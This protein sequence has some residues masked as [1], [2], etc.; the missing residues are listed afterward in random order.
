MLDSHQLLYTAECTER[1]APKP[2]HE[3]SKVRQLYLALYE[4]ITR[5]DLSTGQLLPSSRE[6]SRQLSL[7]RNTVI[8]V[9]TQLNDEGLTGSAGRGGTR[10]TYDRY[11]VQAGTAQRSRQH[12]S[13][14]GALSARS[15]K[16]LPVERTG[17]LLARG[18]P[19]T[20]LFPREDWRRALV[21]ASR[22][23]RNQLAYQ[24]APLASLQQ[25][26]ARYLAIYRSL[27]VD[28]QQIII[29]SSTRQ[30]LS[31]AATLYADKGDCAWIESPGYQGA[32]EAFSL[33]GL[34]LRAMPVDQQGSVPLPA[35][36]GTAPRIIYLTPCF[37]YPGGSPLSATRRVQF[38]D[39]AQQHRAVIFEDDYDSEFR[40]DSEAR[41]ALASEVAERGSPIVLH[42]GTFSKL[43]FP[44]ARIAWLV[45][46]AAHVNAACSCLR[47]LGG[48]H[49]TVAQAAVAELLENGVLARHLQ[50]ARNTYA[51]RRVVMVEALESSGLFCRL[52]HTGGSLSMVAILRQRVVKDALVKQLREQGIGAQFLEDLRWPR[53]KSTHTRALVLGLGNVETLQIPRTI[54]KLAEA[55]E[56]ARLING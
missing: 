53:R 9:Y 45:V 11:H 25:A 34:T 43:I 56:A 52:S 39:L 24:T 51:Q 54:S 2:G 28:P 50:R 35:E 26:L 18:T 47:T 19:D 3:L 14:V 32:V 33:L 44:A 20:T 23:S 12:S 46:P 31:L 41:P 13:S 27:K 5:G 30:S 36:T 49:N 7:G 38:L 10:V 55:I 1:L 40:D 8:A 21:K 22:L 4:A 15:R 48:G 16:N 6:L 42:A 37:Q 17:P 29:T